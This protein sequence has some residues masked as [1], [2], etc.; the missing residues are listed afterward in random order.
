M[1]AASRPGDREL[2]LK[3][4]LILTYG[5]FI[6]LSLL[7]LSILINRFAGNIFAEFIRANIKAQ[8]EE[9][10]R[11]V[12]DQYDP[13]TEKFDLAT[14]QAMGMYFVHQG[15]IISVT[16]REE[17]I[18]WDAR[19]CDMQQCSMVMYEISQRMETEHRLNG[20]LRYDLYPLYYGQIPIGQISIETYGPFFYNEAESGFLLT[21][22]RFLFVA[23]LIFT[24]LGV[25]ISI[26]LAAAISRPILTAAR[27]ARR[28]AGGN[29][30]TRIPD[31]YRTREL[32][33]LSRAVNE[34]A[35][36]LEKGE[37]WQKRLTGDIA[38][39]LRTPLTCLQGNIEAMIDGIWEPT[40]ERLASCHE[41]I[42]RLTKLVEDLN[43]LS[44]LE[45]ENLI[46]HKTDFDLAKLLSTAVE[47]FRPGAGERGIE[48][49][50]QLIP[51]P[52]HADYDR[53]MQ[54]FINLLSNAV[55]YTDRGRITLR[56]SAAGTDSSGGPRYEVTVT[57]TGIG[58]PEEDL[59]HIFERFYRS[60]KSRNRGSGGAGIGLSIAAAI[61][62]A[63]GGRIKAESGDGENAGTGPELN[64]GCVFRVL[65]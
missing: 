53:L 20:S 65:L 2:S 32:G 10:V 8:C 59:P 17:R 54:V 22:N 44:I 63:H 21:L 41:E 58:I 28:I 5:L 64:Q 40:T 50:T 62:K 55:K 37:R 25:F 43:F 36:E 23:G 13:A 29:F 6:S 38:H 16:D 46:L 3:N 9:I 27:A 15:Y 56:L 47:Q 31:N 39:E 42:V 61:V 35:E 52:I 24:L 11:S 49:D 57:D 1:Q 7:C 12:T 51:A 14:L 30:S 45:Q 33:E 26:I 34:L 60:D 48:I 19:S 18:I 4:R